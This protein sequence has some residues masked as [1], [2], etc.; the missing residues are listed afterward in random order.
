MFGGVNLCNRCMGGAVGGGNG[1]CEVFDVGD[2]RRSSQLR[3][4][5]LTCC[6][7]IVKRA[8]EL[9]LQHLAV[10]GAAGV[11]LMWGGGWWGA[12]Q[13]EVAVSCG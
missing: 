5:R 11:R 8:I 6:R 13:V 2:L 3:A 1:G 4:P 7:R 10:S 12:A 9:L